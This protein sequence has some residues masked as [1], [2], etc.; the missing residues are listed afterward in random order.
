MITAIML[1]AALS[2][3]ACGELV[4]HEA[5]GDYTDAGDRKNL[6]LVETFHFTADVD[7]LR[8]GISGTLADDIGYTLE[9]FPNH[10]RALAAMA[11]LGM[12]EKAAKPAGARY[13]V[14][15]Y[16]E[17]ALRFK[18]SDAQVRTIYGGYLLAT[19]RA[20]AALE[21]M[22]K[23]SRL[24]PSNA[25]AHY[26]L[27]LLFVKRKDFAQAREHAHEAYRLGFPLPGLKKQLADAGQWQD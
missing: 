17:R 4:P 18:P 19:N 23:A 1:A 21:Q 16:F 14:D 8:R 3:A 15:C 5:G 2:G 12:R 9:H 27:G 6:A 7:N 24:D 11:R 13:T 26:N 22:Q 20:D 10:H 25:T